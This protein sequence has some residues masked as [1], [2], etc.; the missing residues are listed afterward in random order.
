MR[1]AVFLRDW[2]RLVFL[3]HV[4][5][6]CL[7]AM[8]PVN[9]TESV[10]GTLIYPDLNTSTVSYVLKVIPDEVHTIDIEIDTRGGRLGVSIYPQRSD[11]QLAPLYSSITLPRIH[12]DGLDSRARCPRCNECQFHTASF[13]YLSK[14]SEA[15]EGSYDTRPAMFNNEFINF[16]EFYSQNVMLNVTE[17]VITLTAIPEKGQALDA[18]FDLAYNMTTAHYLADAGKNSTTIYQVS[19]GASR[20][21]TFTLKPNTGQQETMVIEVKNQD[22]RSKV[23]QQARAYLR[24][25][26]PVSA[27]QH[28]VGASFSQLLRL[29]YSTDGPA[30]GLKLWPDR[31]GQRL[32]PGQYHLEVN[33]DV[34]TGKY[35]Y[36]YFPSV[37]AFIGCCISPMRYNISIAIQSESSA[38]PFSFPMVVCLAPSL[39]GLFMLYV[40]LKVKRKLKLKQRKMTTKAEA[41]EEDELLES[42]ND[43]DVKQN[44]EKEN[45]T[46]QAM[47]LGRANTVVNLA[48][49]TGFVTADEDETISELD[50]E[51]D[52][53]LL[54]EMGLNKRRKRSRVFDKF[55]QTMNYVAIFIFVPFFQF[56][57]VQT[58]VHRRDSD[59]CHFN[60]SCKRD[61]YLNSYFAIEGVNNVWSSLA[62]PLVGLSLWLYFH[63]R[64]KMTAVMVNETVGSHGL[65]PLYD[66][67]KAV[68][69][70][71]AWAGM[72]TALFHLCPTAWNG[73]LDTL[74][75]TFIFSLLCAAIMVKR[76]PQLLHSTNALFV[77]LGFVTLAN[78]IGVYVT[79]AGKY[80]ERG[81]EDFSYLQ[82]W[83]YVPIGLAYLIFSA[84]MV[85]FG[86][87]HNHLS[88]AE[89][90][91]NDG[92]VCSFVFLS[93]LL[94]AFPGWSRN[95][96][97]RGLLLLIATQ[98]TFWGYCMYNAISVANYNMLSAIINLFYFTIFYL[99][100]KWRLPGERML[101]HVVFLFV[102]FL[103]LGAASAYAFLTDVRDEFTDLDTSRTKNEECI[104]LE[105]YDIHDL[106]HVLSAYT[107]GAFSLFLYHV[108]DDLD[109]VRTDLI[110]C[111]WADALQPK[112]V[113]HFHGEPAPEK[114]RKHHG[115][116][117]IATD[118]DMKQFTRDAE[119]EPT[120]LPVSSNT[121]SD[122]VGS[123]TNIAQLPPRTG[124]SSRNVSE[125]RLHEV[126]Y[127][128]PENN[129]G[130]LNHT[131]SDLLLKE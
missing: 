35:R 112:P 64:Y 8:V 17:L 56:V 131:V 22:V 50:E 9:A 87:K 126:D 103:T 32:L 101:C 77:L 40:Y 116:V 45:E 120:E 67:Y 23:W 92:K 122:G 115:T 66:V 4:L 69:I 95:S 26:A 75:L 118:E 79:Q 14:L 121:G 63:V 80:D 61:I 30:I 108:D 24:H 83:I 6:T 119:M 86:I 85:W 15:P 11:G 96:Y 44:K 104:A 98:W 68:A 38:F 18:S 71:I 88:G 107:I 13:Y 100:R 110:T 113:V 27:L 49:L 48:G 33:L 111:S 74:M 129:N 36:G 53:D 31:A 114:I 47:I 81:L 29:S 76:S 93:S 89:L 73:Q 62:Y 105:F 123:S 97:A 117:Q 124:T 94:Y 109:D 19:C 59:I 130:D 20:Y 58:L 78:F 12:Q 46:L 128:V 3:S 102:I 55:W 5:Q 90:R 25:G 52:R 28:D 60:Y 21:H 127:A 82:L 125:R 34:W 51:E 10:S 91:R 2:G 72:G 37:D 16:N 106:W 7:A 39:V 99:L 65:D 70:S 84:W 42:K 57:T 43:R 54:R 1:R 41:E